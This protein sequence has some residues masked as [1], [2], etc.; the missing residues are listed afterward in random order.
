MVQWSWPEKRGLTVVSGDTA[1]KVAAMGVERI[2]AICGPPLRE[3]PKRGFTR[4]WKSEPPL[5]VIQGSGSL[6]TAE[7]GSR[8]SD[9]ALLLA[10]LPVLARQ[11]D[12]GVELPTREARLEGGELL[13]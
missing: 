9:R 3:C 4:P 1:V 2:K 12:Q 11:L 13:V 7:Q 8:L 10:L 5:S 6:Q